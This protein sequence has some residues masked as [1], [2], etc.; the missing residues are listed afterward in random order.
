M[1]LKKKVSYNKYEVE[2]SS[3]YG[4]NSCVSWVIYSRT[5][6]SDLWYFLKKF[7]R[8]YLTQKISY[9]DDSWPRVD[10]W[11][12]ILDFS[13]TFFVVKNISQKISGQNLT[14]PTFLYLSTTKFNHDFEFRKQ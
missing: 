5:V 11:E 7:L 1:K 10:F 9:R 4:G 3:A 13:K 8:K 6:V 2:V 12:N 14:L